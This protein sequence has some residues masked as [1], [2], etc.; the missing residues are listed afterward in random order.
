MRVLTTVFLLAIL[1]T[2]VPLSSLGQ[3]PA[4][5]APQD[6]ERLVVGTS[7]VVL[8]AIVRDKKGHPVKNLKADDFE[9][10]EDGVRQQVA[11]FRLVQ[12]EQGAATGAAEQR[13]ATRPAVAP[14][15]ANNSSTAGAASAI[16]SVN[17]IGAVALVFDRLSPDARAR[18]RSAALSY[19][20]EG[21]G[22]GDFA[23][24][25]AVNQTLQVIQ[26]Y[27]NNA[28]L[29]KR[30]I[31]DAGARSSSAYSSTTGQVRDLSSRQQNLE[32]ATASM[33]ATLAGGASSPAGGAS[34]AATASEM[35]PAAAEQQL[36][37]MAMR[38]LETFERIERDQQGYA[39]T[40]ALL[41]LINSM[42]SLSGRKA[43]L[44]FSEGISIPP[45]VQQQFSSVISNANRANVSI[46]A[47]DAAGL[48]AISAN[49]ETRREMIARGTKRVNQV[50]SG[51]DETGGPMM[52]GLER[53]E[54][55]LSLNPDSGLGRL[56]DQTGGKLISETNSIAPRLREIGDDLH[57]YYVLTYIPKNQ[58]L[59]GR[60]RTIN[61]KL[62]HADMLVQ[63]RKG[64]Y[65]INTTDGSPML[66]YEAPALAALSNG[67]RPNSFM[68]RA[69]GFN[70]PGPKTADLTS[71]LVEIPA[72]IVNYSVDNE[73]KV[74]RSDFSIIL[75]VKDASQRVV[76][77]F[78][79][80]YL[81]SGPLT[82]LEAAKH[83]EILFYRE[84][85]LPPGN[86]TIAVAGYDALTGQASV[87]SQSVE[88]Q[89]G[90][91]SKLRL[92]SLAILKRVE[93]IKSQDQKPSSP[94]LYG[95][96]LVY[97]NVGEPLSKSTDKQLAFFFT[98]YPAH[99]AKSALKSTVE[100]LQQHRSLGQATVELPAPDASGRVQFA[101]ALPIEKLSPGDYELRV[102][103][104]DGT[105]RSA[106]TEPFT[107]KP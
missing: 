28:Q 73:K 82:Q 79:N 29:V 78:S 86:Y 37:E 55:L 38:S 83:G 6:D 5:S 18:A 24:V 91:E 13:D 42:R 71:F 94:F 60:F 21:L 105:L 33:E 44:F 74:F 103:V 10:Y 51:R 48:R 34:M 16:K 68:M 61:V 87:K 27:T 88:V 15:P 72:G 101:S 77:K 64:Y 92:S 69:A 26:P 32:N 84:A 54:D 93:Q 1:T 67:S 102:T 81:L 52:R 43:I 75:L 17:T 46:Y 76:R 99:G 104:T 31:E 12:R 22:P 63:T 66:A 47:V 59:D 45:A 14:A 56:A 40:N 100:I 9:V 41:A 107:V 39:T 58:N 36:N 20:D 62:S 89:T 98:A 70:F 65:A 95:E 35:G 4:G 50:A 97:P 11:S 106:R 49:E 7:E 90:D 2:I 57:S 8:D 30:A 80:Q 23:G 53:N 25:F 19:V 96:V 85:E 3:T